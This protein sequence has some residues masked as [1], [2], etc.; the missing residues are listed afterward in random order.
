MTDT[1]GKVAIAPRARSLG[2]SPSQGTDYAP[3][4]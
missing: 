4:P 1:V 2:H 3:T